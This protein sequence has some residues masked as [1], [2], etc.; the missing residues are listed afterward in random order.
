MR[1]WR[2][3]LKRLLLML[4]MAAGIGFLLGQMTLTL[5]LSLLLYSALNLFQLRRLDL[6]LAKDPTLNQSDPPESFGVW[7][8]IFDGIYRLQNQERKASAYLENIINKAQ[9][10]SVALEIGVI[11]I[12]KKGNLDW[13]NLACENLLG[14][15]YPKDRNQ[16][17]TNLIRD[18]RFADYYHQEKYSDTLKIN[19]PRGNSRML[20][21]QIALFGEHERL[22]IVR[23]ITQLHRL[24]SMRKDF[25]GNVSH[26]LGTPITV[27]KGYLEA[28]MDNMQDLDEKWQNP[29]RQMRAQSI[30][31]EN[32]V[33]DLL[34][35][36][37]LETETSAK[38][39]ESIDILSLLGEIENDTQQMFASKSHQF[40]IQCAEG[41]IFEGK[42]SEIYSA[43]SN[44]IG[45]AAKYT[46]A[47]GK[48]TVVVRRL[49]KYLEICVADNGAGIEQKHIPRLTER[50]YR[51]DSSRSSDSGG[52]GLGL[53]IVKHI[54]SRHGGELLIESELGKGS[55][56]TCRLPRSRLIENKTKTAVKKPT[57]LKAENE[58]G[59]IAA[60]VS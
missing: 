60:K 49:K 15:Q 13:W 35:L 42:R 31:M 25:V 6:W 16:S 24:E 19:A 32:I 41:V 47:N 2:S 1:P 38:Q 54:L 12:N 18:P 36:A 34:T 21:F 8:A 39:L 59:K 14:L 33:R 40:E 9:E 28:I 30:R 27:I 10:S 51:V 37:S 3:E 29:M 52:T 5:L 4:A 23:D 22:M 26:E 43:L 17:V 50:F 45:N 48:I 11:M 58:S 44:L 57:E 7:G 55:R 20:E 53:A 46:P 56:F